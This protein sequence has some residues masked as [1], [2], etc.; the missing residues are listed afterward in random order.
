[1]ARYTRPRV[2]SESDPSVLLVASSGGHLLLLHQLQPWWERHRHVWV[3]FDTSDGRSLLRGERIVWAYHPTTRNVKNL[4]RNLALAWRVIRTERPAVVVSTGAGVAVPF[5]LV[6]RLHGV[7]TVYI[8][9]LERIESPSL[10]GRLCA[11]MTDVFVLQWEDQRRFYPRGH[12][13]GS[14]Y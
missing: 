8:E 4:L 6:A 3:T 9:V 14:L 12:V 2:T 10:S 5:F 7:R 1:M 13:V 11:P